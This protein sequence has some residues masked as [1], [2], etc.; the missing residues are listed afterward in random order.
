M[1]KQ[2]KWLRDNAVPRK[3]P[4]LKKGEPHNVADYPEHVVEWWVTQGAAE[5]IGE[6]PKSK[7]GG[8]E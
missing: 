2:F 7:K 3:G 4:E 1:A 6:K 5:H 8:G